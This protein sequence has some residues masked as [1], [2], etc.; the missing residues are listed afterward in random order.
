M[1]WRKWHKIQETLHEE[2]PGAVKGN[3]YFCGKEVDG[4]V[5]CF[6]CKEFV[7]DDC[8]KNPEWPNEPCGR[9]NVSE[10]QPV[11]PPEREG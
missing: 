10:H 8:E 3:C 4:W 7:C 2:E 5:Y 9:H 6:G 11:P 1:H